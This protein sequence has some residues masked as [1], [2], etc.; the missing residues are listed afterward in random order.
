MRL[1]RPSQGWLRATI[2]ARSHGLD[3]LI[4]G[5]AL[6]LGA[7]AASAHLHGFLDA[8]AAT[9][10]VFL[11]LAL[12]ILGGLAADRV[13]VFRPMARVVI[14]DRAPGTVVAGAVL[15][16]TALVSGLV[17]L[18][19]AVVVAVPVA[20]ETARRHGLR[21]PQMAVATALTANATSF[22]LPSSNLTTLLV[23]NRSPMS[24]SAYVTHS[25]IAWLLV[26][27]A[28][29]CGLAVAAG[30]SGNDGVETSPETPVRAARQT[31]LGL[32]PLYVCATAIRALLGAAAIHPGTGF[33]HAVAASGLLAAAVNNL[34]AASA[35]AP[36][37]S[38]SVWATVAALA[39][40][41][42]LVVTGSVATLIAR[43]LARSGATRFP[44]RT[45]TLLGATLVP[46]Q[47]LLTFVG[48][49]IAGAM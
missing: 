47:I 2:S 24:L 12:I 17:N 27:A 14:P 28:T 11:T 31:V 5:A 19:V 44:V 46:A 37:G 4:W 10:G 6:A 36:T 15:T 1:A 30:R 8:A 49:H 13:G 33:V 32:L 35:L 7:L 48:L 42:N 38:A 40:G 21:P 26:T 20:V 3:V 45:F 18:D 22:L 9:G 16:C 43:Q 25:W 29:V 23:L 34:P 41:P 39:I